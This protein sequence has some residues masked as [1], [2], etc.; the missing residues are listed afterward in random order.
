[1]S[2]RTCPVQGKRRFKN[3]ADAKRAVGYWLRNHD[4]ELIQTAQSVYRCTH[5]RGWHTTSY[6]IDQT[7]RIQAAIKRDQT[8]AVRS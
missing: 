4:P 7:R 1:M 2:N 5:C 6:T 8:R 3:A